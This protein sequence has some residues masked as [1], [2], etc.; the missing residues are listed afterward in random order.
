LK[1]IKFIS[2]IF[3]ARTNE[4]F[5]NQVINNQPDLVLQDIKLAGQISFEVLERLV[6]EKIILPQTIITSAFFENEFQNLAQKYFRLS[7]LQKPIQE[8]DLL[9]AVTR[10]YEISHQ[11]EKK[12]KEELNLRYYMRNKTHIPLETPSDE[13]MMVDPKEINHI[14]AN[15]LYSIINFEDGN[16]KIV[17]TGIGDIEPMLPKGE[18]YK[19]SRSQIVNLN[20]IRSVSKRRKSIEFKSPHYPSLKIPD[21]NYKDFMRFINPKD[22]N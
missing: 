9:A 7:Y 11:P 12:Q 4:E 20:M 8:K 6:D 19:I 16:N 10:A 18:F 1:E 5:Y 2:Q 13:F 17:K 22:S 3:L 21:D 14:E 15:G